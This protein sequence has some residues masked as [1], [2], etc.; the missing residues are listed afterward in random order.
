MDELT[1]RDKLDAL[2]AC[3]RIIAFYREDLEKAKLEEEEYSDENTVG[4]DLTSPI[5][6]LL[7]TLNRDRYKIMQSLVNDE[8]YQKAT[9][10][11]QN[12]LSK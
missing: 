2:E 1:L 12:H 11:S 4:P 7:T 6:S 9:G 10:R 5:Q 3:E 8:I